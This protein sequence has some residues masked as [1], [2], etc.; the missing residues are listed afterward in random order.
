HT[1]SKNFLVTYLTLNSSEEELKQYVTPKHPFKESKKFSHQYYNSFSIKDLSDVQDLISE[2]E[3]AELSVPVLL[4]QYLKLGGRILAFNVD[5]DF[6]HVLDGLILVNLTR[7]EKDILKKYM[8][9][10]GME[11]YLNYHSI[12]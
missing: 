9:A 4:R 3:K 8:G 2:I 1:A 6:N 10:E 12:S 7:T 5:P 11:S